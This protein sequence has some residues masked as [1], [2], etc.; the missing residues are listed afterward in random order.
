[1]L[2]VVVGVA[3]TVGGNAERGGTEHLCRRPSEVGA[4]HPPAERH[5]YRI[6]R[7]EKAAKALL[8]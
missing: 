5:D 2:T 8:A 7:G 1:M 3:G 6:T 4:V